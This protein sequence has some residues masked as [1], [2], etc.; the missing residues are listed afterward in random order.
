MSSSLHTHS[1][2]SLLDGYATPEENLI[3]ASKLGLKALAITE[4]GNQYSWVY[5]DKLHE[6]YPDIKLLFGV[7]FYECFDMNIKDKDSK[8]FH[9]IAIAKNEQG[10]IAINKLITE[11]NT[12]GFYYKPRVDLETLKP[13]AENL[14]VCS[15]CLASKLA[16]EQDYQKCI[17]YVEEYK[18]IFPNFY[19][20][21]Q[22]H[23]HDDQAQYNQKILQLAHDTNTPYVITCDSHAATKEDLEYQRWHVQIAHDKE[24]ASEIYEGCYIQSDKEI[25]E[26]LDTQIGYEA[27]EIGL[28]ETDK[29]ADLCEEVHMPFQSPQLPDFPL[30]DGFDTAYDYLCHLVKHGWEQRKFDQLSVDDK[31]KYKK[32]IEYE[33]D[34]IHS[35]HFDGYF[36]IV[37]DFVNF[38]KRNGIMV[39]SGRG[40]CAGSLVCYA[41]GITDLNPMKYGLIFERFLNPERI[42]MPDTDTDVGEREPVIAYLRQKYG[43]NRVCQII[44][45]SFITPIVAIKDV[46]KVLGFQYKEMDKLSK[47]FVYSTF[48][49]CLDNNQTFVKEHPKYHE[50]FRIA[51][52]LFGRVKTVSEHAGGVG[53]V[54][55]DISDYMGMK[56]ND[57]GDMVIQ[58]DK[59]VVEKIG[60]IKF[61][62]LG[63]KTLNIVKEAMNDA[64]LSEY[65][66]N[67][68]NPVFEN[69]KDAYKL[70]C[71]AR[72]N[73]VFQVESAGMKDLLERLQPSSMEDVS[74][75]LALYRPDAMGALEEFIEC[76]NGTKKASYIHPDMKPILESTYGVLV[77]QEQLLDIVRKFGGRSYGEADLFR[78]AIG[79]K[80]PEL[81]QQESDKL[82]FEIIENGYSEEVA[83]QISDTLRQKGGYLFNKSHSYS[84]AV[85]CL[86]TAYL[87]Q[88]YTE[89]FFKALLNWN[90]S[91]TGRLN[92]YIIDA[93]SFNVQFSHPHINK[94]DMNFII[95]NHTIRFGLSAIS[96]LGD[97]VNNVIINREANGDYHNLSDLLLRVPLTTAQVI[98]LIKAGA[99][100]TKNK[101]RLMMKYIATQYKPLVFKPVTKL[102]SYQKLLLEWEIDAEDY[103]I[104]TKKYDFDKE[105]MLE[106]YNQKRQE[107][108]NKKESERKKTF[109]HKYNKYFENEKFWEFEALHIFIDD[110]PF[111]DS[112]KYV[113]NTSFHNVADG[114]KCILVGVVANVQKKKDKNKKTF[115]FVNVYSSF[116]LVEAIAWHSTLKT[117]E[118]LIKK[119][120]QVTI[121]C[122]KDS[123]EKAVIEKIRPYDEWLSYVKQKKKNN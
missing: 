60:I 71:S 8:Y 32:R 85:L 55:T 91:D 33:L 67:I 35:M 94:S 114:D 76:A 19:L 61:D 25:H 29:I 115:A 82:Y 106:I 119:G 93:Q 90:K 23:K 12:R 58:V 70:L 28:K 18:S 47:R 123:D 20:E 45:F 117:Y 89:Y 24:T 80:Q 57:K 59:R 46:G 2:Y 21:M 54:T 11:S 98:T 3:R 110:N 102:P 75:V 53:I 38:A 16:R 88:K 4:H 109:L 5:Y 86:Q 36:L 66:I 51:S 103:R 79:K 96:G 56:V 68:N 69:A 107:Q 52:K 44:N 81:V 97:S 118:D 13:Y 120:N 73:G 37:W 10:R 101:K 6:K 87:K 122:K 48:Q 92:K 64:G 111:K 27:V 74:V 78:K 62:I 15:A 105:K 31:K 22:S 108:F 40:S 14:I 112:Y 72:T 17:E 77:Y 121:L 65:D 42:S 1:Q 63:V 84:Y 30:P 34:V 39:G 7:E 26:I 100:P 95:D 104:G 49:E 50:L 41:L 116:G 43:E 99:I 9:L 83:R 113:S